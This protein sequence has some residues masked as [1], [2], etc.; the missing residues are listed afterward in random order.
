MSTAQGGREEADGLLERRVEAGDA[1]EN[2][3]AQQLRR[4]RPSVGTSRRTTNGCSLKCWFFFLNKFV[5]F[6]C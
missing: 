4:G 1:I 3:V 5:Y 6:G 2:R